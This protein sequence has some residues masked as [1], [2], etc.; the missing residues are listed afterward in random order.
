M[1]YVSPT[2]INATKGI[3]EILSY[4]NGATDFWISRMLM[5]AVFVIFLMGY[6]RSKPDDDFVGALDRKSVV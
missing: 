1:T 2:S 6:L 4:I 3:G 5:V